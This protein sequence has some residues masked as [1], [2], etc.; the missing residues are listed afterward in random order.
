MLNADILLINPPYHKRNNSGTVFPLGLGYLS[1]SIKAAGFKVQ[2]LDCASI[3]SSLDEESLRHFKKWLLEKLKL[4]E[5]KIAIGIGPCTTPAINGIQTIAD[6]C[7]KNYKDLPLIYGGPL[8][9][10][11][12][13]K[14]LFFDF[15]HATAIIGGDGEIA[16]C[17]ILTDFSRVASAPDR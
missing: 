1:S 17:D 6:V 3:F 2:I 4:I 12:G 15:L 9:S 16:I 5:P 14:S 10:I 7:F 13:Q 8:A 11:P